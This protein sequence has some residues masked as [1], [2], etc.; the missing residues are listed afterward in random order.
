MKSNRGAERETIKFLCSYGGKILPRYTDGDLRYVGGLTRVLAV[1]RSISF[2]GSC[3]SLPAMIFN[4]ISLNLLVFVNLFFYFL[5]F[6]RVNVE[7]FRV[8]WQFCDSEV[9]VAERRF[10]NTNFNLL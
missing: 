9:P 6:Y 2:A 1:D 10:G 4:S 3:F 7:A 8:L 5:L